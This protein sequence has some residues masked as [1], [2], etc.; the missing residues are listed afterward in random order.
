MRERILDGAARAFA[1]SGFRGTAMPAIAAEAAVSVGLIYRYFPS[2]EELFLA[3]C[4]RETDTKL[5]ELA[6][7]LGQI[8]DPQERLA[9]VIDQF[10]SSLESSWG[11][12]VI[13]AWAEAD[14]NPRVRDMLQRLFDQQ[15]GFAAYFIRE[16][17]ARGEAP[18]QVDVEALSLAAGLLLHGT[19]AYQAERGRAF[20][21][22]AVR[23]AITTALAAH[24]RR[25]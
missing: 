3:V 18:A 5:D 23:R 8:A 21:P 10:V 17:V 1:A 19:I 7:S 4:A 15:R 9:S 2:K 13:H 14:G 25:D 24:L 11:T 12:I 16:A 22:V 20:D 6:A